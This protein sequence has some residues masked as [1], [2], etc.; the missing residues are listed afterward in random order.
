MNLDA[1]KQSAKSGLD[2]EFLRI[3]VLATATKQV[4]SLGRVAVD[5]MFAL[6]EAERYQGIEE[7]VGGTGMQAEAAA[8]FGER[9]G[10]AGEFGEDLHLD[11]AEQGLGGPEAEAYLHDLVGPW[12]AHGGIILIEFLGGREAREGFR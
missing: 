8:E 6:E 4:P 9:F 11:C 7:V 1:A 2:F 12:F 3:R 5:A 10:M